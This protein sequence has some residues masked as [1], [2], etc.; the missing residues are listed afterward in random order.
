M[1]PVHVAVRRGLGSARP[2]HSLTKSKTF[3]RVTVSQN[4][5]FKVQKFHWPFQARSTVSAV[6]EGPS[7]DRGEHRVEAGG[8]RQSNDIGEMRLCYTVFDAHSRF[9]R[10]GE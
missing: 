3:V 10:S 7:G 4:Y 8:P 9:A 6:S 2:T 1:S 5:L